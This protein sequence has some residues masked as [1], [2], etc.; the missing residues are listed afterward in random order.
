MVLLVFDVKINERIMIGRYKRSKLPFSGTENIG[1]LPMVGLITEI[2]KKSRLS[3]CIL[4][5]RGILP[6]GSA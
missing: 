1:N 3:K 2:E 6:T 5:S 4:G